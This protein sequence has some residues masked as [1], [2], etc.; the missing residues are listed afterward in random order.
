MIVIALFILIILMTE[1]DLVMLIILMIVAKP[2]FIIRILLTLLELVMTII[3][4]NLLELVMTIIML[5]L[6]EL[7]M[8]IILM[9]VSKLVMPIIPMTVSKLVMPIIPMTVSKLVMTIIL[10]TVTAD[11]PGTCP[12][13]DKRTLCADQCKADSHCQGDKKCCNAD[14]CN[15]CVSPAPSTDSG[16]ALSF[17]NGFTGLTG[18]QNP[19]SSFLNSES[20]TTASPTAQNSDTSGGTSGF[21]GLNTNN[22][23]EKSAGSS[24]SD[25]ASTSGQT[26]FSTSAGGTNPFSNA[27]GDLMKEKEW[28][29]CTGT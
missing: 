4:L 29:L 12:A 26:S 3:L 15:V 28:R 17:N 8:T 5:T 14:G 23:M 24:T 10:M 16:T 27:V 2:L 9:T 1:A 22:L 11:K 20:G 13:L 19:L 25:Q 18:G 6:L 7:V 21:A